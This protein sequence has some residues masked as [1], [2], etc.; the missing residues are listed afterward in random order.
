LVSNTNMFGAWYEEPLAKRIIRDKYLHEGEKTFDDFANRVSS[1]F[2]DNIKYRVKQAMYDGDFFLGGR[3]LYGAGSK[4]K[5]KASMSNCYILPMPDDNIESIVDTCKIMA[6]IFSYGGGCGLNIS[7]LRP[8][9]SKV[10]NAARTSTGAVSFMDLFN[11]IGEIIG[12]NHRRAALLIG[13]NC[14]HPDIEEFLEI[15]QNN[16][17]IQAANISILFTDEFMKAV[18]NNE[19]YKL[20]FFTGA[21]GEHIEKEINARE[22][23]KKFAA[24][25]W[26]YAEPGAIFIDTV[27]RS[28][29][30]SGYPEEDYKINVSNPCAEY[31]GNEYNSCNLGSINLYNC[32]KR[33]FTDSAYFDYTKFKDLVELGIR[34]LDETL[35]YGFSMQPLDANRKCIKDWRAIGLGLFGVADALIALGLRYGSKE[36]IEFIKTVGLTMK[37]QAFLISNEIAQEVASFDKFDVDYIFKSDYVNSLPNKTKDA[38]RKYGLGNG[39]LLSIAP[40]GTISTMCGHTGGIEPVFQVSYDRTTHALQAEGKTF[41][42]YAKSVWHLLKVKGIDPDNIT[43]EEIK[44][45]FPYVVDT[46]DIKPEERVEFQ[47]ALQKYVDNAISSTVNLKES[48]TEE[49][50]FNLYIKAWKAGCKGI[51]VFRENCKRLSILGKKEET[52]D[53]NE[54]Q[55]PVLKKVELDSVSPVK[56]NDIPALFGRTYV[57]HTA[58][59]RN[60]YVTVNE[61]DGKPFEVFV[62]ADSGCQANINTITRLTSLA[63]RLGGKVEDIVKDLRSAIC[64]ACANMIRNGHKEINK[65]CPSCIADA[66]EESYR[67]LG[68]Q[69]GKSKVDKAVIEKEMPVLVAKEEHK[70]LAICPECGKRT[71]K[72]EGKCVNCI[73]CGYSKCE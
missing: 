12:C 29:I 32:V 70:D 57:Y 37:L 63:L 18:E 52:T 14:N 35:N 31:F 47:A 11:Q 34:A 43:I 49:D 50:I 41:H 65:S 4:G 20:S 21:T 71:L 6:R 60:F 45:R 61:K 46:Y 59:V 30:L 40:T 5:F 68:E 38:I 22:F 66:L 69:H 27:R 10:N 51:T 67:M 36:S 23:F 55:E 53:N 48:A 13:L 16:D 64:P 24:K 7:N 54:A 28:N 2:S 72:P 33:P 8:K 26:D 56:R 15:K 44:N 42:I 9:D 73:E 58:C 1:I 19:N 17:K 62:G 25:Q 3:S 39:S